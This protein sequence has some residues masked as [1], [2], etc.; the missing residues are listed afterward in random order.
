MIAVLISVSSSVKASSGS[1][2]SL[3]GFWGSDSI[4]QNGGVT[5]KLRTDRKNGKPDKANG[6]Y[7]WRADNRLREC[8]FVF[9]RDHQAADYILIPGPKAKM[10]CQRLQKIDIVAVAEDGVQATLYFAEKDPQYVTLTPRTSGA[11]LVS[12][13]YAKAE[14]Q[15]QQRENQSETPKNTKTVSSV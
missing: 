15:L 3:S 14:P 5:L 12:E 1:V 10:R 4:A 9:L 11:K 7:Y 6:T 8:A 2:H 13:G